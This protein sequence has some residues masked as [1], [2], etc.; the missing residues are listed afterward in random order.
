MSYLLVG[1][2]YDYLLRESANVRGKRW[3]NG[4]KREFSL[5]LGENM[6]FLEMGEGATI[7]YVGKIFPPG[8]H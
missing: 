3:K 8:L 4:E 1:K 7:S 5:Y 2:K 6:S